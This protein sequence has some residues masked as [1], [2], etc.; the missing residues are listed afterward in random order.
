MSTSIQ[1]LRSA[2]PQ[3]RPDPGV[4]ADGMP[5][6]VTHETEPGLFFRLRDGSLGKIG[7][8]ALG[9]SP[10]NIA[11]LGYPGNSRGEA[12]LDTSL[13]GSPLLKVYDGSDWV[14][15]FQS[16]TAVTSVGLQLPS[17]FNVSGSPVT[18]SGT[19]SASLALQP[20]RR[21]FAGPEFGTPNLPTFRLLEQTDIPDLD[22]AKIATGTFAFERIPNLPA[23]KITS[24]VLSSSLIPGLD[25]SKITTGV[26]PYFRGGTGVGALP[27]DGE[28][29]IGGATSGY[30][31]ATLT[32]GSNVTITNGPG[33]ITIS[34]T[35]GSAIG[36]S[37]TQII[38]NDSGS[39]N[40]SANLTFDQST[41]ILAL[42]GIFQLSAANGGISFLSSG[43]AV[44]LF[45]PTTVSSAYSLFLP[46]SDGGV[47]NV[48]ITD[49]S[50]QLSFTDSLT[51]LVSVV[52]AGSLTVE[53]GG[54]DSDVIL[55]PTGSGVVNVSSKQIIN[56]AIPTSPD[57]AANKSYVDAVAV[58]IQPKA[59]V[60]A[61]TT[62]DVT[63]SGE[64][65]VDDVALV[66]GD[67]VLVKSQA[68]PTEN[69]IYVVSA[70][71][72]SRSLDA[73]TFAELVN[74]TT[75]VDLGTINGSIT[76]FCDSPPGGTLGVD[77]VDWIVFSSASGT[78][79]SVGLSMPTGFQVTGSPVTTSG[80]L[81]VSYVTQTANSVFA[82]PA[83]GSAAAPTFRAL[84]AADIPTN[85]T[86]H[87][88]S[89]AVTLQ[90]NVSFT[91]QVNTNIIPTGSVSL[92]SPSAAW[93]NVYTGDL[94]LSN[95]GSSNDVDGSWGAYTIQEGEDDLFLIN[96]RTGRRYKFL[97]EEV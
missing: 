59:Q 31:K 27:T 7:P 3:L 26:L 71:A 54:T 49:G 30:A 6:L 43:D 41:S 13:S 93:A 92:G 89:G 25:T 20:A 52:G 64:Q 84:V 5:C 85:L 45:A 53:A 68:D 96:R 86:S 95:E 51:N 12:W 17:I 97:L 32:A 11:P 69:G 56:L 34:A 4:L 15:P 77:P 8:I 87:T 83:T 47:G 61:A 19:L 58:G 28:L 18:S 50:G 36:G 29:L 91:G 82:G 66:S 81:A 88:F 46:S 94:H 75:F 57:D 62:A 76:F 65:T 38:F 63:L 39:A 80:T 60:R 44:S 90:A 1:F 55:V 72:W 35:G 74:A 37:D 79:T 42:D 40:G 73:D 9:D 78:V 22:A 16:P 70:G 2:T 33:S 67:R 24:G 10:P 23:S 21:I 48:M 14:V